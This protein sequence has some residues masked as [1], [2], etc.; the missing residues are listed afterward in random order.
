MSE[1]T[2]EIPASVKTPKK[3]VSEPRLTPAEFIEMM[4][5]ADPTTKREF[6]KSMGLVQ[7]VQEVKRRPKQTNEDVK[8]MMQAYGDVSH[9]DDFLP[10]PPEWVM[11]K[12]ED[13]PGFADAWIEN[14]KRGNTTGITDR[15]SVSE[16]EA[17]AAMPLN[18]PGV[19]V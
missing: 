19:M 13:T 7:A 1:E 15:M 14:W 8:R 11:E 12:D 18:A 16:S 2:A 3:K 9:D 4:A 6:A 17:L 5:N 10:T